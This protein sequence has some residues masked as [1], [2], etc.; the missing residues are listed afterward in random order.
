MKYSKLLLISL[1]LLAG[2]GIHAQSII[3]YWAQNDNNLPGGGFGFLADPDA[4]PQAPDLG[5]GHLT[6]GGGLTS[7]T[8]VNNNGDTVYSFI[9]SFGGTTANAQPGF[10]SGG[11]F[12]IQGGTDSG[13]NGAFME[14]Q[15]S[16]DGLSNL[17]ISYATQRTSTGFSSQTWSW[18]TD[19]TSFTDFFVLTD[20]PSSFAV[21]E[22]DGPA[23]LDGVLNAFLRVT[24]DGA[25]ATNGNNR[26]DNITLTAIPEPSTYAILL[27]GVVFALILLRRRR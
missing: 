1:G 22:I 23:E 25:S 18:S 14:L 16:M 2:A 12:S 15:F 3:A 24:F 9:P 5:T 17:E 26:L 27:G 8:S 20:I 6:V 11:S 13:N 19:G 21:R 10:P 4:F 7:E